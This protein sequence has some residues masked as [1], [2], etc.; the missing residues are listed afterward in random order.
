MQINSDGSF[1]VIASSTPHEGNWLRM[2]P[3]SR[4]I[5]VRQTRMDHKKE[6]PAQ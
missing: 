1:E 3:E 4:L 5:Q 6:I 2:A